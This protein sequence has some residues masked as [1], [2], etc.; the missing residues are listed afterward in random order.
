LHTNDRRAD[1]RVLQ[2][3]CRFERGELRVFVGQQMDVFI[4]ASK[5]SQSWTFGMM[6][7]PSWH[8]RVNPVLPRDSSLPANESD[9]A[10]WT[11]L[12]PLADTLA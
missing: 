8:H 2:V 9:Y 12:R 6:D 5:C 3:I 11:G 7:Q 1:T 10:G 4:N